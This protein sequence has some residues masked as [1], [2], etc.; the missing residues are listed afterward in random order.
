MSDIK[1]GII[2]TTRFCES[3]SKIFS[4]YI[5]YIDRDEAVKRD[6]LD[7]YNLFND[8]LDYMGDTKKTSSLFSNDKE[9]M[10]HED[11]KALQ[12]T[13]KE[14]Q[15][16]GSNLW[17]TVISFDNRYL[18]KHGLLDDEGRLN[19]KR[20]MAGARKAINGMLKKEEMENAIWVGAF[21]YNT[22]NIHIHV[23]TVEPIPLRE[24]KLYKQYEMTGDGKVKTQFNPKTERYEK[25]PLVDPK[26]SFVFKEGYRGKFKESSLHGKDGLRSILRAEIENSREETIQVTQMLRDIVKSKKDIS[27]INEKGFEGKM[28]YIYDT[29]LDM[30]QNKGIETRMWNY[31]Q[32][33]LSQV[34]PLIDDLTDFYIKTY[35]RDDFAEFKRK[36]EKLDDKYKGSYGGSGGY[37]NKILQKELYPRM[38]NAILR[39]IRDIE[40]KRVRELKRSI[41]AE[42]SVKN[43]RVKEGIQQLRDEAKGGNIFALNS[44]GNIFISNKYGKRDL[45]EAKKYFKLSSDAGHSYGIK[46]YKEL[47][48]NDVNNYIYEG[49]RDISLAQRDIRRGCRLL[50][51]KLN[52]TYEKIMAEHDYENLQYEIQHRNE[53]DY[54]I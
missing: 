12:D 31:N 54:E 27:L 36:L 13:F 22:D 43:G 50:S 46:M 26:G 53:F 24:K 3:N 19:E 7:K 28:K 30:K 17:Q 44:L 52:K 10:T 40:N 37:S 21:H 6:N 2:C 16:N 20:L 29:L 9:Y 41:T 8:Y 47:K 18:K 4:Q 34:R 35:H 38:G 15:G 11:K 45:G 39:E 49:K 42:K 5:N 25:I 33:A 14:A 1:A 51:R 23:A 32:S 48:K